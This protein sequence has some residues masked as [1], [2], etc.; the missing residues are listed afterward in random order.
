MALL[1][2]LSS[3][4]GVPSRFVALRVTSSVARSMYDVKN[5]SLS[6]RIGP[7]RPPLTS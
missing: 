7:P 6:R 5:H 1:M 3:M 4:A 2:R